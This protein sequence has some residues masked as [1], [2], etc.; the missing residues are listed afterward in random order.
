MNVIVLD[1]CRV[2]YPLRVVSPS[3]GYGDP[4]ERDA[5]AVKRDLVEGKISAAVAREVYG[6][7]G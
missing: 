4:R 3:G 1:A 6:R 7:R 5:A 2:D